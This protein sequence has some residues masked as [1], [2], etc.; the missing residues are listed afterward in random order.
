MCKTGLLFGIAL[1][2]EQFFHLGGYSIVAQTLEPDASFRIQ[3]ES[4]WISAH[5]PSLGHAP[6]GR[7][8]ENIVPA[9]FV[10]V[11]F[12]PITVCIIVSVDSE[13]G[14]AFVLE[15]LNQRFF[16]GE[17]SPAWTS[18]KTPKHQIGDFPSI[19]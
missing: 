10:L 1:F 8:V 9:N 14:E 13:D 11:T 3:Q 5:S 12:C 18:P 6:T 4:G 17:I 19:V 7:A 16:I 15:A 2:G